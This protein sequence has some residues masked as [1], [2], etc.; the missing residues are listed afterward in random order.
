MTEFKLK[1]AD[2][3]GVLDLLLLAIVVA[4]IGGFGFHILTAVANSESESTQ[5]YRQL[6]MQARERMQ[7]SEPVK[8]TILDWQQRYGNKFQIEAHCES[9]G[10]QVPAELA[11]VPASET[12]ASNHWVTS[13]PD[14]TRFE[15]QHDAIYEFIQTNP[16]VEPVCLGN[17]HDADA[18]E[19]EDIF[20]GNEPRRF[21]ELP[22]G[23]RLYGE[24]YND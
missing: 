7:A 3:R 8:V 24:P 12:Y 11:F 4:I 23:N 6:D 13:S 17:Y 10:F 2:R 18:Y 1:P 14:I 15:I 5:E 19:A 16:D 21:H 22:G 20:Y 9:L